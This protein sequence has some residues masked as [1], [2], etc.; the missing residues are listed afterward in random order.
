MGEGH[1]LLPQG[2]YMQ[3]LHSKILRGTTNGSGAATITSETVSGWIYA[4]E[5]IDGTLADNNTAVLSMTQTQSGIDQTILTV[6]AGEGDSDTWYY[7]RVL[8]CDNGC[9]SIGTYTM[10][11]GSGKL[12]LVIASGGAAAE[13]GC[14]VY[15]FE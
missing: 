6:G 15:M 9:T 2:E 1:C 7:P 5:W 13:G 11:C 3:G 8:E 10:F 12:K 4:V 14:I